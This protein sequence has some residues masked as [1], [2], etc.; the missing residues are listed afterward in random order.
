MEGIIELRD[1]T[2]FDTAELNAN[3][4]A[5]LEEIKICKK[6]LAAGFVYYYDSYDGKKKIGERL[7]I[8]TVIL[9]AI[10]KELFRRQND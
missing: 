8:N 9:R 3:R 1:L 5:G 2:Q 6:A 10:D 4:L 7:S